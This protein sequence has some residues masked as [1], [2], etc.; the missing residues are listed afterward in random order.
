MTHE[1][2]K[3]EERNYTGYVALVRDA[4]GRINDAEA[5]RQVFTVVWRVNQYT[6]P[7]QLTDLVGAVDTAL[8]EIR[9]TNIPRLQREAD[10]LIRYYA[11]DQPGQPLCDLNALANK[12]PVFNQTGIEPTGKIGVT[13]RS[14]KRIIK[15]SCNRLRKK[16]VQ[17]KIPI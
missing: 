3:P 15:T 9:Q 10:A 2:D 17:R 13:L 1:Q 16:F 11:L 14:A 4:I 6:P 12:L 5:P 8:E 7:D